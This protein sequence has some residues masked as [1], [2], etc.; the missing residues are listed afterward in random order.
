MK[1]CP[2]CRRDYYDDTLLYCLDDGNALLEGPANRSE[3]GAVATG[4]SSDEP[5]TAILH[6][7]DSPSEAP[8]RAQIH[9]TA[10]EPQRGQ[11][12]ASEKQSLSANR[13]AKPLMIVG[14]LLL[15]LVAGFFGY[16]YFTAS[17]QINSIAVIPFV[18]ESGDP[19]IEYLSDGMTETLINSLSEI[20]EVSVKAR[21]LVFQYK[22]KEISPAQL[23]S[24]LG[25]QAILTGRLV[26]RGEQ[27]S[28]SVEL[29]DGRTQNTLWGKKYERTESGLVTLQHELARDVSGRLA[30]KPSG[31]EAAMT[32]KGG[33]N[34]PVAY[35]A[36]AKGRFY[37][38][39]RNAEYVKKAIQQFRIA[40][41]RDPGYALAFAG[42]ADSYAIYSEYTGTPD[43]ESLPQAK[44]F[45]EKAL[46][47][48]NSLGAPHATLGSFAQSSWNWAEAEREY[49]TAIELDPDYPT[50]YHW[51]SIL[52][53]NLGRFDESAKA[54]ERAAEL[55]PLSGII[56]V[57]VE[58]IH[59]LRGDFKA[60]EEICLR[61]IEQ[62]PEFSAVYQRLGYTYFALGRPADAI[63]LFEK[64]SELSNRESYALGDLGYA[65]ARVGRS[66]Q[67]LGLLKELEERYAGK[68]AKAVDAA[69]VL[70]GL[71][72]KNKAFEWLE[73]SLKN[74]EGELPLLRWK[75]YWAPL[76]D[77]PRYA[78]LLKRMNLPE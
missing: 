15:L 26:Q 29:I 56:A 61:L 55:D 72:D 12:E 69:L 14:G 52:L 39:R 58:D 47:L 25:V 57:N 41:E 75:P 32:E 7:T 48:E 62:S 59:S 23:A 20:P 35:Q 74:K 60:S 10:A 67:A 43:S 68:E 45:A 21:T 24:E 33:T 51:Y 18:N 76:R 22:G 77:D 78:S 31:G 3:P 63:P 66:A 19:G 1:R 64:A 49:K 44:A 8:T 11:A 4:F 40:T 70:V 50:A 17:N 34:D 16:R 73:R 53:R 9:T 42:L 54:I 5:Q 46:S 71:G 37:W 13:A 65:Y 28:L 6:E 30:S 38:N 2:E 27:I 36:Y